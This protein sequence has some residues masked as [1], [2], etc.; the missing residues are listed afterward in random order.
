MNKSHPD[1]NSI[2]KR[3]NLPNPRKYPQNISPIVAFDVSKSPLYT[4][5]SGYS[6]WKQ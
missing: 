1:H 6:H 2:T 5:T 4:F 3:Q